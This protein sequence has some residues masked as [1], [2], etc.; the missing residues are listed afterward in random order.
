[1]DYSKILE[2]LNEASLFDLYRLQAAI[3]QQLEAPDR[4]RAV[5]KHLKPDQTITYFDSGLNRLVEAVVI[6]VRRTRLLVENKHD[7]RRWN[8]P[9]YFVNLDNVDTD[10]HSSGEGIT[11]EQLKVGDRVG[12]NDRQNQERYGVVTR[13]NPKTA[14]LMVDKNTKWRVAYQFLFPVIDSARSGDPSALEGEVIARQI[15]VNN[16]RNED[17]LP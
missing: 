1:M 4:L 3:N 14:T 17:E 2:A 10:L 16:D 6:K 13:I 8:I 15:T 7:G 5:K 11:K 12:F 9:F